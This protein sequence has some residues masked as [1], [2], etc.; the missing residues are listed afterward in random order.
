MHTV[1]LLFNSSHLKSIAYLATVLAVITLLE[2]FKISAMYCRT[3]N[4]IKKQLHFY[5]SSTDLQAGAQEH[6]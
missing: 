5:S 1:E 3:N 6:F 4:S 2:V